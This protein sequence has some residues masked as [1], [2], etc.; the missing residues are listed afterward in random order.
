MAGVDWPE[1]EGWPEDAGRDRIIG[2]WHIWQRKGG[3]R[4]STDDVLTAW[5]AASRFGRRP[6]RYLDLG[7]GVGSVLFMTAHRL[8]PEDCVGVEAQPQSALMARRAVSELPGD[9]PTINIVHRDF[10]EF[11]R[12]S[13]D[14]GFPLVT[15]S[16]PYFPI[17]TGVLPADAQRR[18]CR[19]EARGGVEAYCETASRWLA[20]GGRF[21]FVF[22][23]TWDERVLEAIEA[24]KLHLHGRVD[25][26]MRES[27]PDPFLTVY[28]VAPEAAEGPVYSTS[29][30]IRTDEGE[31]TEG[32]M[33]ARRE[34]GVA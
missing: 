32:Y 34:L 33:A 21:Y 22:Q 27:R 25:A 9:A 23:T 10:R 19:F 12:P 14:V 16:P 4:T 18:A 3:H 30:T 1:P 5:F 7:C 26:K 31:I 8:R 11:V 13:E 24:A 6:E 28:E 15:G 20:P 2:D 29:V 17:G